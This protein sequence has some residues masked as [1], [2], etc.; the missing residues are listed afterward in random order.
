M[1]VGSEQGECDGQVEM[2]AFFAEIG[3]SE[4]DGD[5]PRGQVVATILER[6]ANPFAAFANGGV[7]KPDDLG[8]GKPVM[9]IDLDLNRSG[10]YSPGG[11]GK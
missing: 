10:L 4:I 5:G 1:T 2:V 6:C 7:G 3:R 8:L 11:C 9:D